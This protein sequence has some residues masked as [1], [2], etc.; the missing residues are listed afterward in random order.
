MSMAHGFLERPE[1][2]GADDPRNFSIVLGG[3]LYQL[4]RKAHLAGDALELARRRML[5]FALFAW[6][7]LLVLALAGGQAFGGVA[8]PF[9]LDAQAH[10]RFLLAVPLLVVAEL[11]VHQRLRPVAQEFLARG[12]VPEGQLERFREC[13]HS[14][15]RLRNSIPAELAMIAF[16]Y[17]VGVPFVWRHFA[18]LDV[19]TWYA[20]RGPEGPSLT[21][22]GYW[23]AWV[24]VP[25]FQFLLLRWYFRI[26][27]WIRFLWQ[28]S[29][30]PLNLSAMHADKA[31]GLGFLN[32]TV[33]AFVPLLMAHG[34]MLAG[35]VANRIFHAGGALADSKVEIVVV[36]ALLL[37]IVLAPLTVFAP[38]VAAVKRRS[39]RE[40]GRLS[41]RY[42]ADFEAK[43]IPAG[44]P[45]KASPLGEADIQSLAD[46]SNAME[47]VR[48]TRTVAIT[49]EAVVK[50][51]AAT[52][53]PVAPLILTV[54]PAEELFNRL[55]KMLV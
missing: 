29:R 13:V 1:D 27:I 30:I 16:I 6:L 11:L 2:P 49:R 55:L 19:A 47:T 48:S 32:G 7:P 34:A 35:V 50:L 24:S 5:L 17:G 46:L 23:Y 3:P 36:V 43:W 28:V 22:A 9:I 4:L 51:A 37:A 12:L 42:V 54:I 44:A 20:S 45:A 31:A 52:L 21:L 10:T 53:L 41:Q 39:N 25:L 8:V 14:A 33:F 26:A 18:S 40:Y 38:Q 15:F